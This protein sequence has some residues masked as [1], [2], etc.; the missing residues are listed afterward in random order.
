MATTQFGLNHPLSNKLW[1]K[2][3]FHEAL[4]ATWFRKFMGSGT[5]ALIQMNPEL[6]KVGDKLTYGLRMLLTGDGVQGDETLEGK[7]ESL[8]F[9]SDSILINQLRHAVKSDGKMSEQ[10]V[11]YSLRKE[12]QMGL[13]DWNADKLDSGFMNQLAGNSNVTDTKKTGN[14]SSVAPDS[15]HWILATGV[16]G[17]DAEAS[18]SASSIFSLSLIDRAKV[19][20][21]TLSPCIRPLKINGEDKYVCFINPFQHYQLRTNTST[22][23]YMDIQ[24]AAITGGQIS[25]NPIY[26]GAIAEYNNTV[27]HESTRVPWGV[28]GASGVH[29]DTNLGVS[30]VAR[31]IFC[32]A[33]AG[34]CCSG[35]NTDQNLDA[36][37]FEQMFDY[38]NQL[39]VAGAIIYG[40][41][42]SVFNSKAFSTIAISSYSPNP[43]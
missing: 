34:I 8:L 9:Y 14:N 41:K 40:L 12:A 18:L 29:E 7:E 16:A 27:I 11:P 3:L 22:A 35:R 21:L 43:N 36:T 30:N 10:R 31:A 33:Q 23:Q 39:G 20:A 25:K 5:D 32:G 4:K 24:K 17:T 38:G 19:K 6:K 37:W 15:E 1:S 26:T 2:K 28:S 42:K 13:S